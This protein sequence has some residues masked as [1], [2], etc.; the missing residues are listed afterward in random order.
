MNF[1]SEN[2]IKMEGGMSTMTDLVFLLL[3]FFIVIST[4]ITAGVNIDV[5]QNG[6][7]KSDKKILTININDNNE[8]LVDK[9]KTPI[10]SQEI[11]KVILKEIGKDS[12]ISLYGSDKSSW[13]ASVFIIDIAK[14]NN[15][16]ISI[17]GAKK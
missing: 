15:F 13:E 10:S 9:K 7:A 2:K 4:M 17:N 6:G 1:R 8:F 5:P 3:I 11:K 12:I 14:Q 16:K